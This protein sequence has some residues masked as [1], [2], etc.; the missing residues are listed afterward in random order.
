[1]YEKDVWKLKWRFK[2]LLIVLF[3]LIIYFSYPAIFRV[4]GS[5]LIADNDN[6]ETADIL[7]VEE[8]F[9][10]IE[11]LNLCNDIYTQGKCKDIIFVRI[12]NHTNIFSD[13]QEDLFVK[14]VIDSVYK[15]LPVS[16][17]N[18][19]TEHPF[20]LNKSKKVLEL[21][22]SK[23]AKSV[24]VL[25]NAFHSRRTRNVYRKIF[26][27]ENIKLY[28][29]TYFDRFTDNNWWQTSDGFRMV[30]PEFLKYGYYLAKG[31]M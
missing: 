7:F 4:T 10:T 30:I 29:L 6:F 25:T 19:E 9:S 8:D 5:F 28:T 18:L 15:D 22:R 21:I 23:N 27:H 11:G 12:N 26:E 1:M 13:E 14:G 20:T 31:Y 2:F 17:L 16:F 24:I 3:L